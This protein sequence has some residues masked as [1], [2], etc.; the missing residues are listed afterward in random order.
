M[1]TMHARAIAFYAIFPS[2]L[3]AVGS[4]P[5]LAVASPPAKYFLLWNV[6]NLF[7]FAPDTICQTISNI[8]I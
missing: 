4:K 8:N 6:R 1:H 3:S 7:G 5:E 2:R